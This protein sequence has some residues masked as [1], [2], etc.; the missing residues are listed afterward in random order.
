MLYIAPA[1]RSEEWQSLS[2][3]QASSPCGL[4][5]LDTSYEHRPFWPPS[6]SHCVRFGHGPAYPV[7]QRQSTSGAFTDSRAMGTI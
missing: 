4:L 2:R 3:V 1:S 7:L 6:I 5:L